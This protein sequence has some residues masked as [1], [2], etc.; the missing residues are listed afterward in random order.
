[1][2]YNKICKDPLQFFGLVITLCLVVLAI[3]GT[4]HNSNNSQVHSNSDT[5]YIGG[6]WGGTTQKLKDF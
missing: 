5:T 1:M 6:N 3:H 2:K 4:R